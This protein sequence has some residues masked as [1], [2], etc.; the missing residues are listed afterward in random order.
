[1]SQPA[2]LFVIVFTAINILACLWLMWWMSRS[3]TPAPEAAQPS[4]T[5]PG[6]TG[7]VWDGDLE[8]Y[9]NPLPRWW[10]GLFILTVLFGIAYLILYPG[11]GNFAG[12][13]GWTSTEA[14]ARQMAQQRERFE[15]R[16]APLQDKSLQ[17]LARDPM[18]MSTARNLFA[19]N[20][21]TCH[22]SD[23]R[24]ARGFP[25][26][27]D[28]DWLWGSEES[29]VYETIAQGR[30]GVMP[31]FG[32][33]LGPEGVNQVASYV[34][35]LSGYKAPEDWVAAG[36]EKFATICA[37][38][39]G[40]DAKGNPLL[41]AP[42]LTD[43]IWLHGGDFDTVRATIENGR[44]NRMPAHQELLG[45]A[46]VRLLTA[47]V[48]SLS[49][50]T[51]RTLSESSVPSESTPTALNNDSSSSITVAGGSAPSYASSH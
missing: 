9:N 37:A 2:S 15:A 51:E 29:R 13:R 18:A 26:L 14:Y 27:T 3:R 7:H 32:P 38:C 39:H 4:E 42:N 49:G 22:G 43:N 17:E 28:D 16:L 25:N 48:L 46:K 30:A 44:E 19:A 20:C 31:A 12:A 33:V 34:L 8:E 24:G 10:L 50:T 11:L 5:G 6:K 1:M 45:E 41:G 47:Y 36:K 21:S 35:S 23:A 40:P